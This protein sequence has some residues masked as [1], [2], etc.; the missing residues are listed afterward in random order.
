MI[1]PTIQVDRST[2]DALSR[3]AARRQA[4]RRNVR[5]CSI[6]Y[7]MAGLS[8]LGYGCQ[9]NSRRHHTIQNIQLNKVHGYVEFVM[10]HRDDNRES[11]TERSD[12]RLQETVFEENLKLE[13]SGYVYHPNLME[14]SLAG[15]FG[16]Q[17]TDFDQEV[18]RR[19]QH[20][21]KDGTIYE[22]DFSGTLFQK[23][24]YPT[25]VYARRS[26]TL[27]PRPFR[28]SIETVTT[29]YGM[30]LQYVHDVTPIQLRLTH[31]SIK[32]DPFLK[33][34]DQK[35]ERKN[36]T[37]WL[38]AQYIVN[39]YHKFTFILDHES[40]EEKPFDLNYTTDELT[41]RHRLDFGQDHNNRS[42]AELGYLKQTGSFAS[43]RLRFTESIS[44]QHSDRLRSSH[45]FEFFSRDQNSVSGNENID[46][47]SLRVS[48]LLEHSLYESLV[49]QVSGFYQD[50]DFS[51]GLRIRRAGADLDLD[52]RKKNPWGVLRANYQLGYERNE[53]SGG[54]QGIE[55]IDESQTFA[56]PLPIVLSGPNIEIFSI[57]II[58][59]DRTVLYRLESDY[60]FRIIGDNVEIERIP[61][62]QIQNND[63][64]L[65]SYRY[66]IGGEFVLSTWNQFF[67][68]RQEFKNGLT[69]YYKWRNQSQ[70]L[71]PRDALGI[72]PEEIDSNAVG[73]D[74]RYQ[75]LNM[76]A[77]YEDYESSISPFVSKRASISYKR[78]FKNKATGSIGM[79]WTDIHFGQ[80]NP[81]NTS[82]FFVEARYRRAVTH[83]I[84][85]E[86]SLAYRMED[87]TFSGDDEG[88]EF[89]FSLDWKVRKTELNLSYEFGNFKDDFNQQDSHSLMFQIRRRF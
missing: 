83:K 73:I 75:S 47:R 59:Q 71:A 85:F 13:T 46:E 52:Y 44:L 53:Q 78:N 82:L 41:L 55:V 9:S 30:S 37:L 61:I 76:N 72:T 40:R 34:G 65:I 14:F 56:G 4:V 26:R 77:E 22:Y 5:R 74:F 12:E 33:A 35:G 81:R 69:P 68:V 24:S 3:Y 6:L 48:S 7:L 49:T 66:S 25:T 60:R 67:T 57:R 39:E 32:H 64:V 63:T 15:L 10:R 45:Q 89:E 58:S 79:H 16:L 84:S 29:S 38:K 28:S 11:Q 1:T 19:T 54:E 43:E 70:D 36:T 88:I 62:G 8:L 86:T 31:R 87:D 18:D 17:R 21:Q 2:D 27:D 20:T 50:Q 23:K 80:P 42:E 51:T